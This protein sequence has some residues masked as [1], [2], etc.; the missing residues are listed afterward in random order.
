MFDALRQLGRKYTLFWGKID[1]VYVQLR[2][3][4][5]TLRVTMTSESNGKSRKAL[6]ER[7]ILLYLVFA[8]LAAGLIWQVKVMA[9]ELR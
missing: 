6:N 9:A 2:Y 1:G 3:Y 4:G 5:G 7:N 8:A